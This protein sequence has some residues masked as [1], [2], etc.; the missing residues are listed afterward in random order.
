[1]RSLAPSGRRGVGAGDREDHVIGSGESW[2]TL[3]PET[4]P[5]HGPEI[6]ATV[7]KAVAVLM[8]LSGTISAFAA[9]IA[10]SSNAGHATALALIIEGSAILSAASLGFF[11]YVLD[12]LTSI[13]DNTDV[14]AELALVEDEDEVS[15]RS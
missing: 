10:L 5:S 8:L 1:M 12:L 6:V 4:R 9:G 2:Q 3:D 13:R 14:L 7:F 15:P 11:A